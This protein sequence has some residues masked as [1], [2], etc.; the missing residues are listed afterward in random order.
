MPSPW[1][2]P[3]SGAWR[4]RL[5]K[6]RGKGPQETPAPLP[7]RRCVMQAGDRIRVGPVCA[8]I[9]KR[10]G[11]TATPCRTWPSPGSVAW[12]YKR[13][14]IRSQPGRPRTRSAP[15]RRLPAGCDSRQVRALRPGGLRRHEVPGTNPRRLKYHTSTSFSACLSWQW[16]TSRGIAPPRKRS[17][18]DQA[19]C[20]AITLI[21]MAFCCTLAPDA[22]TDLAVPV[23]M[24]EKAWPPRPHL[25][26]NTC[27]L[28]PGCRD[29][30]AG[31]IDEAIARLEIERKIL[32]K[33]SP[34][35]PESWIY[36]AMA[37]HKKGNADEARRWP[38]KAV[39]H[40]PAKPKKVLEDLKDRLLL[41]EAE[42]LL[43]QK[44]FGNTEESSRPYVTPR[45]RPSR[46]TPNA[47]SAHRSGWT[48][49][50]FS[51]GSRSGLP[52]RSADD[53]SLAIAVAFV[54]HTDSWRLNSGPRRLSRLILLVEL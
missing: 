38:R 1:P 42:E 41:K 45:R 8:D 15:D 23:R 9:L 10:F 29:S 28:R 32:R 33:E 21:Y 2:M 22:V 20:P 30:R 47:T 43:S 39:S 19:I 16:E 54:A 34:P 35:N 18:R 13:P 51:T 52:E 25:R 4:P 31:R 37:H 53:R 3:V 7:A 17:F 6:G 26:R 36:L 5:R 27:P 24:V 46:P 40:K 14:P 11:H 50:P 48:S 44:S 12:L 49:R